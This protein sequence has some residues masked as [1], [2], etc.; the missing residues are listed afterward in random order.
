[1]PEARKA[2]LLPL[3]YYPIDPSFN[4]PAVLHPAPDAPTVRMITSTG[5]MEEHRVLGTLEFT[6]QGQTLKL[7]AFASAANR[8]FVPFQD[9][10]SG[11]RPTAPGGTSIG[12]HGVQLV[13]S[14]STTRTTPTAT[15]AWRTSARSLPRKTGSRSRSAPARRFAPTPNRERPVFHRAVVFDFDGVIA[16]S[17]PLHFRGFSRRARGR[18]HRALRGRT[19]MRGISGTTMRELSGGRG[20]PGVSLRSAQLVELVRRKAMPPRGTG[21][22]SLGAVSWSGGRDPAAGR[23]LSAGDRVRRHPA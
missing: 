16:N 5:S 22:R 4:V 8:L 12:A 3:E 20:G 1:M 14:I 7:T 15:T 23:P 21:T 11:R 2:A 13:Q 9:Q 10:T 17:E 18:R 6:V 19:T